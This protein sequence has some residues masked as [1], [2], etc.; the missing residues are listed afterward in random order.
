MR[1]GEQKINYVSADMTDY[2][3]VQACITKVLA[4]HAPCACTRGT[5]VR[6]CVQ[7]PRT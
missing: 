6:V 1:T 7:T 3:A 4:P 5:R 2:A